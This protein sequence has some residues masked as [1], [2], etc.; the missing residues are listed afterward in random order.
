MLFEWTAMLNPRSQP[1]DRDA[2]QGLPTSFDYNAD[3]PAYYL[4]PADAPK[5]PEPTMARVAGYSLEQVDAFLG[6]LGKPHRDRLLQA[7]PVHGRGLPPQLPRD[8]WNPDRSP[9]GFPDRRGA[10]CC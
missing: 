3:S 5:S 9:P 2:W 8:D 4:Q 10:S 7:V 6:K 1:G